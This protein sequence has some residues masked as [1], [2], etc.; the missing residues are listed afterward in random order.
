MSSDRGTIPRGSAS[1]A[2]QQVT[3]SEPTA[4]G[5]RRVPSAPRERKPALAALA[6]IL[7]IGGAAATG[8]LF[9]KSSQRV[10]A[11]EIVQPVGQGQQIPMSAMKEVQIASDSQ[12]G[13]VSWSFASEVTQFFAS[14]AI[15]TGTLLNSHM[16]ERTNTLANGRDVVGLALKD[17]QLPN[18]LQ[19]GN[20]VGIFSTQT[21]TTGCQGGPGTSLS[22]DARVTAIS[23]SSN[24]GVTDVQ[25]AVDIT[26]AG[27][28]ACNAAN[29]TAAVGILPSNGAG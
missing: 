28:V 23:A 27:N 6:V 2:D 10:E 26:D 11:I 1:N 21:S 15:P 17:G 24:S 3:W 9:V 12:V 20:T 8:L 19:V 14:T 4:P 5:G 18:G 25:V 22:G 29:G 13:F 16:V 7:I